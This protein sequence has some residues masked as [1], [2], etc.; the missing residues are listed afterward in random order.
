MKTL[1]LNGSPRLKGDTQS[2]IKLMLESLEGEYK[3]VNAYYE[4]IAPC[5]DCRY[6]VRCKGCA[7]KDGMQKVYEYI[8]D[9]D[10]I[11]IASPI[12]YSQLTGPLMSVASRLQVYH[13]A[14]KYRKDKMITKEKRGAVILVGRGDGNPHRACE[15]ATTLLSQMNCTEI[16]DLVCCHNTENIRAI[17]DEKTV[18]GVKSIAEYFNR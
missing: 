5:I 4:R 13:C 6:C 8:E 15:T 12:Y 18:E 3:I 2:L 10:N 1:I 7:F 14:E 11:L 16:H 17:H 9:C